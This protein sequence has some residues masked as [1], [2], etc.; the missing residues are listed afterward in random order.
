M[1]VLES[2]HMARSTSV[3]RVMLRTLRG[4]PC[5]DRKSEFHHDAALL[6]VCAFQAKVQRFMAGL[7]KS[8]V[9]SGYFVEKPEPG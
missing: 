1:R 6:T 4:M 3:L 9:G 2:K 7:R 5:V 8:V